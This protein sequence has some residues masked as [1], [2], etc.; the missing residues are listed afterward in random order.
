MASQE[1]REFDKYLKFLTFKAVQVIVQ[2][3]GEKDSHQVQP[4]WKRLVQSGHP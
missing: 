2:S 4:S 1:K 3:R